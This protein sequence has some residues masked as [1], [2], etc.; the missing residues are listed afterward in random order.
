MYSSAMKLE[1]QPCDHC[2]AKRH[3]KVFKG[4]AKAWTLAGVMTAVLQLYGHR[5]VISPGG[6]HAVLNAHTLFGALACFFSA[7]RR[8][9]KY[10]RI[11]P[12]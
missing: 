2:G 3:S 8:G 7:E 11:D 4:P 12:R 5:M 10:L 6:R 1:K 9:Q